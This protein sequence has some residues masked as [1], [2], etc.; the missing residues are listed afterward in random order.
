MMVRLRIRTLVFLI[1]AAA[2]TATFGQSSPLPNRAD[3]LKFAAIG[4]NGTGETAQ[5]EVAKQMVSDHTGVNKK[6][7][8]HARRLIDAWLAQFR[9]FWAQK[10]E[11]LATE[12]ERG[13]RKR[14]RNAGSQEPR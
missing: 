10:L 2:S 11:A 6:A 12:I 14:R 1:A 4:D 13:K 5:Y 3:S 9:G 8:A 7:V